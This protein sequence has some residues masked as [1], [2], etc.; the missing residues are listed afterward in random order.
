[1]IDGKRNAN[2]RLALEGSTPSR[3]KN[4]L[5]EPTYT[6]PVGDVGNMVIKDTDVE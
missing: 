2:H 4:T 5:D 3:Q 1:M 6:P